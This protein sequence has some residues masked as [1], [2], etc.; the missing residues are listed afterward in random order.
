MTDEPNTGMGGVDPMPRLT[1]EAWDRDHKDSGTIDETHPINADISE[2]EMDSVM[3]ELQLGKLQGAIDQL[4]AL[5]RIPEDKRTLIAETD[6]LEYYQVR[7]NVFYELLVY[8]DRRYDSYTRAEFVVPIIN[9]HT[10]QFLRDLYQYEGEFGGLNAHGEQYRKTLCN[11]LNDP[12]PTE[13]R[14][15]ND[16]EPEEAHY[17][18]VDARGLVVQKDS[19]EP[20]DSDT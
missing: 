9:A 7:S 2:E 18:F 17:G 11:A 4:S 12:T 8:S 6:E 10:R 20:I 3:L 15:T 13:G 16:T 14:I 5:E 19:H 1:P